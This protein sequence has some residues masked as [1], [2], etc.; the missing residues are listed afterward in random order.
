M[1]SGAGYTGWSSD[2][3]PTDQQSDG[4]LE[5]F[6][7]QIQ[8]PHLLGPLQGAGLSFVDLLEA[9][10][11]DLNACLTEMGMGNL[12]RMKLKSRL[13]DYKKHDPN[14][15]IFLIFVFGFFCFFF[16]LFWGRY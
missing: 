14:W 9:K 16:F 2:M 6:L 15:V 13:A 7:N 4:A 8:M 11:D 5:H 12:D 10:E 3:Q 1:G